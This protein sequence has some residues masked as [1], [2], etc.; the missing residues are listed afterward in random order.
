MATASDLLTEEFTCP[1]CLELLNDPVTVA[2]GHSFCRECLES[3]WGQ[4]DHT[5]C[6]CPQCRETFT[7]R[8]VLRRNTLLAGVLEKVKTT[9]AFK[10][11]VPGPG[12]AVPGPG[13]AGPG[14]VSCDSCTRLKFKAEKFCL[15]C[16]ANFCDIHLKPHRD[17][18]AFKRHS[19]VDPVQNPGE[20]F[21]PHHESLLKLFCRTDQTCICWLC[22][23][24]EHRSHDTVL[25]ESAWAEKKSSA[26]R[27]SQLCEELFIKLIHFI[28]QLQDKVTAL[29][30]ESERAVVSQAEK[31]IKQLEQ[32]L[33]EL[34]KRNEDLEQ[35]AETEDQIHFLQNFQ[36][37]CA[38]PKAGY[39]PNVTL[40]TQ[41][42][43]GLVQKAVSDLEDSIEKI[44]KKEIVKISQTDSCPL[45]LDP[46]TVH[47]E[48]WLS[49]GNR[50]VMWREKKTQISPDCPERFDG[51]AQVL[52]TEG[53][54]GTCYYWE[55]EWS[56]N[57]IGIGVAYKGIDRK[58][59]ADSCSL[60]RND[61]S[62][63]LLCFGSSY[64]AWHN[65]KKTAFTASGSNKV[66]VYLD[67]PAGS[68]SFYS[69]S[70]TDTMTL[71][72]RFE[73]TFTEHLYPGFLLP[74]FNSSLRICQI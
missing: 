15:V 16:L 74:C 35:L 49:Q 62:W 72:H 31:L 22:T 69:I 39:L 55:I 54:F 26:Q 6:C 28:K 17:G 27:E 60:G 47:R 38:H 64:S 56:G 70:D 8:P 29:M 19:L 30:E 20:R 18:E 9:Q 45:T 65:N 53:L 42:T 50:K 24:Q 2:C 12:Y 61:K 46:K 4:T 40:E 32:E 68:V 67:C 25:A 11:P 66:G 57:S 43:F 48:L 73:S 52:C 71:L 10:V 51:F 34:S 23:D 63:S 59:G 21:C 37:V 5:E 36:S 3:Y 14:D 41:N 7:P 58:G 1:V 33:T 13:Y 44:C